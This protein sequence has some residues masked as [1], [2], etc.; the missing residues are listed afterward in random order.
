MSTSTRVTTDQRSVRALI[1]IY[2]RLVVVMLHASLICAKV[3][4][5]LTGPLVAK[6]RPSNHSASALSAA[7]TIHDMIAPTRAP[8]A[9]RDARRVQSASP[10]AVEGTG[11]VS[12]PAAISVIEFPD[13]FANCNFAT[14]EVSRTIS[15]LIHL[16]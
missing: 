5:V 12:A 15:P 6:V 13:A 4:V 11:T 2:V 7:I 10:A 14:I 8:L 16:S 1:M 3:P 9:A